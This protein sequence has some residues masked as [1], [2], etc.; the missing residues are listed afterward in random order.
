MEIVS[1]VHFLYAFV[2]RAQ[3][4]SFSDWSM[5]NSEIAL[6]IFLL[7]LAYIGLVERYAPSSLPYVRIKPIYTKA[8]SI[9]QRGHLEVDSA[10]SKTPYD[11]KGIA[12][13]V[14]FIPQQ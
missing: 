8:M 13:S 14:T 4:K 3:T 5:K 6:I 12:N 2:L 9:Q 10:A 11:A 7:L 1:A